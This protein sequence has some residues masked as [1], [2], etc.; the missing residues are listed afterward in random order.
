[1]SRLAHSVAIQ[2]GTGLRGDRTSAASSA[3]MMSPRPKTTEPTGPYG[4]AACVRRSLGMSRAIESS[5]SAIR[6]RKYSPRLN[7]VG[8]TSGGGAPAAIEPPW[9]RRT[10][11]A[12]SPGAVMSSQR[13]SSGGSGSRPIPLV[14]LEP[15]LSPVE[16]RSYRRPRSSVTSNRW[17]IPSTS[18]ASSCEGP[19]ELYIRHATVNLA[20]APV[21]A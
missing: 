12:G 18:S 11:T 10:R 4:I 6:M 5:R 8:V 19:N 16:S 13:M 17:H 1:M 14:H 9:S 21:H 20:P 7:A 2:P 3:P 15:M